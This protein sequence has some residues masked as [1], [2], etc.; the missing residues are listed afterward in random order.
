MMCRTHDLSEIE[1][2]AIA[3]DATYYIQLFLD[4]PP[5]HEPL[6]PALGGL[7]GI[8]SHIEKDLDLFKAHRITPFFIF[9]GQVLVGEDDVSAKKGRQTIEKTNEAWDL[10][11]NGTAE[12][13]VTTF[14]AN[15]GEKSCEGPGRSF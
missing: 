7:T 5:F 12:K 15:I 10:Y 14:G 13:A 6:L 11:F 2:C 9:D 3:I 4:T 8:Q 1:D